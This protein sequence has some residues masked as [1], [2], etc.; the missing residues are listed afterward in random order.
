[1]QERKLT[2]KSNFCVETSR[3]TPRGRLRKI[4]L[5]GVE[6]NLRTLDVKSW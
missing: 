3:R 1:V 4:W 6:K 2:T 5:N